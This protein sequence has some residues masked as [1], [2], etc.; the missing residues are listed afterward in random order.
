MNTR[1]NTPD[2]VLALEAA[3]CQIWQVTGLSIASVDDAVDRLG[4][5]AK[6]Y[7]Q[8]VDGRTTVVGLRVGTGE[9]RVVARWGDWLVRH[10]DGAFTVHAEP[11]AEL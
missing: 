3:G 11:Q 6:G 1:M 5:Y 10:P 9:T 2:S 4:V 7:W 8:Q